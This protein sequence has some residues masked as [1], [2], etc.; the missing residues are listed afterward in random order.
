MIGKERGFHLNKTTNYQRF[1][2]L[3][4]L[5]VISFSHGDTLY[6]KSLNFEEILPVF[7]VKVNS[8][9]IRG[10][11]VGEGLPGFNDEGDEIRLSLLD[12]RLYLILSVSV[13]KNGN[14]YKFSGVRF[15]SNNNLSVNFTY[16]DD[17]IAIISLYEEGNLILI[18]F[19]VTQNGKFI[20]SSED[21]VLK[22]NRLTLSVMKGIPNVVN[23]VADEREDS[24]P[25]QNTDFS[26][27]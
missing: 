20:Y 24:V 15:L 2:I 25:P 11:L 5:C 23:G 7:D 22:R 6:D 13:I 12:E 18:S 27:E 10:A 19:K 8:I 14:V 3:I 16:D 1:F 21:A 26:T 4:I 17:H 9:T